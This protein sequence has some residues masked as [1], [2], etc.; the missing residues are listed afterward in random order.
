[1]TKLKFFIFFIKNTSIPQ[2]RLSP[3]PQNQVELSKNQHVL[4]HPFSYPDWIHV[5][6][7][8]V[9]ASV[10]SLPRYAKPDYNSTP[11]PY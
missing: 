10:W 7:A 1:M 5:I 3:K 6:S 4:H 2:Q 8:Q 9:C 11:S